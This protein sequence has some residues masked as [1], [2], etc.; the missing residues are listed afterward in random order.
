MYVGD[1]ALLEVNVEPQAVKVIDSFQ[2]HWVPEEIVVDKGL[3]GWVVEE[4]FIVDNEAVVN[5]TVVSKVQVCV[6]Q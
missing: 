5:V 4:V 2:F 3:N 1:G 6:L